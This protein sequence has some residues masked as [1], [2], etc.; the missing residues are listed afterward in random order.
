MRQEAGIRELANATWIKKYFAG[1]QGSCIMAY[2]EV[3]PPNSVYDRF[4]I[5]PGVIY[6]V[7][8]QTPGSYNRTLIFLKKLNILQFGFVVM[9]TP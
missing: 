2:P 7:L 1:C 3:D 8:F 9:E 4:N 6:P 5:G